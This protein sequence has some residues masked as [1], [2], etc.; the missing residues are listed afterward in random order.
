MEANNNKEGYMVGWKKIMVK[1][2]AWLDG[3]KY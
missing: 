3:S 1:K 2:A